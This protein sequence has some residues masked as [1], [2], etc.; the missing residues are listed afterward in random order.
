[1][2]APSSLPPTC[3]CLMK[4]L[5]AL[6]TLFNMPCLFNRNDRSMLGT[7]DSEVG[8]LVRDLEFDVSDTIKMD[9][10][11]YQSGRFCGRFRRR[12]MK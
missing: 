9:G 4:S 1:M 6:C 8:V 7:R 10:Q 5:V 2:S 3:K 12:L 11:A